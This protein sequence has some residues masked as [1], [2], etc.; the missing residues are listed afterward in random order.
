MGRPLC[1]NRGQAGRRVHQ[2]AGLPAWACGSMSWLPRVCPRSG[3]EALTPG[4]ARGLQPLLSEG[5]QALAPK[6][7]A[8]GASVGSGGDPGRAHPS[9]Q[10]PGG[11]AAGPRRLCV[12]LAAGPGFPAL[13]SGAGHSRSYTTAGA[14]PGARV[15]GAGGRDSLREKGLL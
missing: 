9:S 4:G 2:T 5:G 1:G 6:R 8:P 3:G 15:Q 14:V 13:L 10:L 11:G 12:A 7:A